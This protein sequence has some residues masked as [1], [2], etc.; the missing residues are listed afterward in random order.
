MSRY[1][2]EYFNLISKSKFT[3]MCMLSAAND[4]NQVSDLIQ[5][6]YLDVQIVRFAFTCVPLP[7]VKEFTV[8]S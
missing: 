5:Y 4:N 1:H 6:V 2:F 7:L 3:S 8:K